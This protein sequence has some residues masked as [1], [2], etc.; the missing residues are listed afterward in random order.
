QCSMETNAFVTIL[1][2]IQAGEADPAMLQQI[3]KVANFSRGKGD[4]GLIHMAATPVL[5]ALKYFL[6]DFEAHLDGKGCL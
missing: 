3:E 1:K 5:S 2:K 6:A 4:C